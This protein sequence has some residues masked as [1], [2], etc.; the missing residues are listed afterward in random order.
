MELRI[1]LSL[2]VFISRSVMLSGFIQVVA[3]IRISFLLKLNN[4]SS[5]V[6]TTFVFIYLSVSG[7]LCCFPLLAIVTD[8]AMNLGV[9]FESRISVLWGICGIAG[10]RGGDTF[11]FWGKCHTL[12]HRLHFRFPAA[13]HKCSKFSLLKTIP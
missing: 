4:I 12:F 5:Y 7:Y 3:C 8:A 13:G 6:Y 10:S 11:N 2:S 1:C 9:S